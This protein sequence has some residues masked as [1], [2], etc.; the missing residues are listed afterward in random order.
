MSERRPS[1]IADALSTV[2]FI[3]LSVWCF[4]NGYTLWWLVGVPLGIGTY[5][6][7]RWVYNSMERG[8]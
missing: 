6:V 2:W 5:L 7:T 4:M 1:G 3:V 8:K